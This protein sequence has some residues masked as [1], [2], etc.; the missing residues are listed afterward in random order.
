M[1]LRQTDGTNFCEFTGLMKRM[2]FS[3]LNK[4]PCEERK[5]HVFAHLALAI[6]LIYLLFGLQPQRT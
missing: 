5:L 3:R 1:V 6:R 2:R 4:S